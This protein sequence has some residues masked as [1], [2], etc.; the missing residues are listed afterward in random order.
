[1]ALTVGVRYG[2]FGDFA[3]NDRIRV[4]GLPIP[5]VTYV[6]ENDSWVGYVKVGWV[7]YVFLVANALFPAGL[8]GGIWW[9]S[10]KYLV[11]GRSKSQSASP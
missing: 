11:S 1:M 4:Q 7:G 9:L 5:L 6:L 2:V 10:A 3:L 8:A